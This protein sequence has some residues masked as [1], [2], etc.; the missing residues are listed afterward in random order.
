MTI[1]AAALGEAATL[2]FARIVVATD[3]GLAS[4]HALA[5]TRA[6]ASAAGGRVWLL[7]VRQRP[8]PADRPA[9]E[10]VL[11]DAESTLGM[12][13]VHGL[14]GYGAPAPEILGLAGSVKARLLVLGVQGALDPVAEAVAAA[15]GCS[16][17][18]A[19][20]APPP[21]RVAVLPLASPQGRRAAGMGLALA[22]TLGVPGTLLAGAPST[23]A[24][25]V[26]ATRL[27]GADLLVLSARGAG[28]GRGTVLD[29]AARD[30]A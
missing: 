16:V 9:A 22:R 30:V 29:A 12:P 23:G 1:P 4:A 13:A 28:R 6:L 26:E 7:H 24:G 11:L 2:P 10:R 15:S 25:I 27:A 14:F 5:W 18:L 20:G 8:G 17:L 21:R 3:G 19:R